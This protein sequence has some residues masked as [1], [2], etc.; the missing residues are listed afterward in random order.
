MQPHKRKRKWPSVEEFWSSMEP[1]EFKLHCN[2]LADFRKFK[3][4]IRKIMKEVEDQ[5]PFEE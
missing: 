4:W 5:Q 1:K 3:A 2:E